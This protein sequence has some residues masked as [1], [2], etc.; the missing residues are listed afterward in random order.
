M[1]SVLLLIMLLGHVLNP[2]PPGALLLPLRNFFYNQNKMPPFRDSFIVKNTTLV[3][4]MGGYLG[5]DRIKAIILSGNNPADSC[6]YVLGSHNLTSNEI[7]SRFG[8][9]LLQLRNYSIN[10]SLLSNLVVLAEVAAVT[11]FFIR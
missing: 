2:N 6:F 9:I 1:A 8:E 5:D 4:I 11:F 10:L 7:H 3:L